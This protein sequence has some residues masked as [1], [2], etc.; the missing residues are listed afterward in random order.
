MSK[1]GLRYDRILFMPIKFIE[2]Y[3]RSL[4]KAFT[5]RILALTADFLIISKLTGR[6]DVAIGIIIVSNFSSTILYFL[7]ERLWN[8]VSWGRHHHGETNA[9]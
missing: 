6:N 3:K 9:K 1:Y 2:H 7:H 5:F 8:K 4:T